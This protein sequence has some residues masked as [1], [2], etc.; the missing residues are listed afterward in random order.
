MA[1]TQTD[2]NSIDAAMVTAAIDGVASVTV[3]GQTVVSKSLDELR[4]L[5]EMIVGELSSASG[6]PGIGLRFQ[7]INPVYR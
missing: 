5:R 1:F 6:R 2:L 3:G 4:R 7:Q